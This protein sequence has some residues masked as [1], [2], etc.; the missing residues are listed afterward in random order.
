MAKVT[1]RSDD[2]LIVRSVNL[3]PTQVEE[4][5]L[6]VDGFAPHFALVLT[7]PPRSSIGL[8]HRR[9]WCSHCAQ[10]CR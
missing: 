7:R 6:L 2:M 8:P 3:F 4:L 1:G 5:I 10:R 9:R